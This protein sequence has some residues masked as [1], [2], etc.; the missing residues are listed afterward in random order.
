M[1]SSGLDPGEHSFVWRRSVIFGNLRLPS[2][3]AF[4]RTRL[5]LVVTSAP[6]VLCDPSLGSLYGTEDGG[7]NFTENGIHFK[8]SASFVGD[9]AMIASRRYQS[10]VM[11]QT[12]SE[13]LI[14]PY[15]SLV[16]SGRRQWI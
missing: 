8:R 10:E 6:T 7:A 4:Q 1:P 5:L 12:V 16:S 11:A 2:E 9:M 15:E 13:C 3:S 14:V